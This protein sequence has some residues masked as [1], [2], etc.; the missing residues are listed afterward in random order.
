MRGA[1]CALLPHRKL[2]ARK[3]SNYFIFTAGELTVLVKFWCFYALLLA[4]VGFGTWYFVAHVVFWPIIEAISILRNFALCVA[5]CHFT[6]LWPRVFVQQVS[7]RVSRVSLSFAPTRLRTRKP[8]PKCNLLPAF[9][10]FFF[11]TMLMRAVALFL[12]VS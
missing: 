2:G 11:L 3:F 1:I 4:S 12:A 8:L 10:F 7:F 6:F 9:F 5:S